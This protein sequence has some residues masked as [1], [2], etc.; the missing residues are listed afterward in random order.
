VLFKSK[1]EES[2]NMGI[3]NKNNTAAIAAIA[4]I[5]TGIAH[6]KITVM[7]FT[8]FSAITGFDHNASGIYKCHRIVKKEKIKTGNRKETTLQLPV[9]N[10]NGNF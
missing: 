2:L 9:I 10:L 8:A 5:G 1:I 4:S 7:T 3:G 6:P